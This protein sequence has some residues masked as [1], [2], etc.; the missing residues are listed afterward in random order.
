MLFQRAWN[1]YRGCWPSDTW[2]VAWLRRRQQGPG[3][4][5]DQ[6]RPEWSFGLYGCLLLVACLCT[7]TGMH[8]SG[9]S[10]CFGEKSSVRLF[11]LLTN[12]LGP[13]GMEL[14]GQPT[15]ML[16]ALN[17]LVCNC[18]YATFVAGKTAN[19][20][21]QPTWTCGWSDQPTLVSWLVDFDCE[22]RMLVWEETPTPP[23]AATGANAANSMRDEDVNISSGGLS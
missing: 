16:R 4:V 11:S 22:Q 17:W 8:I 2:R 6:V 20:S 3:P 23:A 14:V 1:L 12:Q 9:G 21:D 10:H 15:L 19:L 7:A 13:Q 18:L 5:C